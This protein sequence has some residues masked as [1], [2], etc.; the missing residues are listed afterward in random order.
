MH[1]DAASLS[2][3]L[4]TAVLYPL[5][6]TMHSAVLN[7]PAASVFPLAAGPLVV[8][9]AAARSPPPPPLL[10]LSRVCLGVG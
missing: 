1:C 10:L 8:V 7:R 9:L 2:Q 3:C 5:V 6:S 4:C